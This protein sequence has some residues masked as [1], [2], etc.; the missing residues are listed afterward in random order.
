[1]TR[2]FFARDRVTDFDLFDEG[3]EVVIRRLKERLA[4]GEAVDFQVCNYSIIIWSGLRF[5][6]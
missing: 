5:Q 3:A 4:Q 2:P 6:F 1:M